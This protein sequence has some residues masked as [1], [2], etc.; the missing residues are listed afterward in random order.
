MLENQIAEM[1]NK[2][3]N[4]LG[5]A[6]EKIW[7][8]SLLQVQVEIVQAVVLIVL[9]M[10]SGYGFYRWFK[11]AYTN[12]D[13]LYRYNK[14]FSHITGLSVYG[15][16]L[17]IMIIASCGGLYYLPQLIINPEYSAFQNIL[18]QLAQFK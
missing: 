3:S 6:S 13:E 2:L 9:T 18:E 5:I 17:A 15:I 4:K 14:E 8:W 7:E 1:L 12:W 11:Y 10:I 16:I